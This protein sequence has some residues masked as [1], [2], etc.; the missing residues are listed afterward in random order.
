MKDYYILVIN[1]GSTSMKLALYKNEEKIFQDGTTYT[2]EQLSKFVKMKEQLDLRREFV[3]EFLEKMPIEKRELSAVA[4]RCGTIV[5]LK[6]GAYAVNDLLAD[7]LLNR[8]MAQHP[9]NLA[10]VLGMEVAREL[11][12]P[13]YTYDGISSSELQAIAYPTGFE[14]IIRESRVH[15]LNM[16]AQMRKAAAAMGKKPE[17]ANI[18]VAHIGGGITLGVFEKGRMIDVVNDT[19]GPF[20]PERCGRIPLNQLTHYCISHKIPVEKVPL[21]IRGNSGT[22]RILGTNSALEME[23]RID[24][25]DRKAALMYEAMAYQIS[26]SIGELAT[27]LKG[28]VDRIVLTGAI[29][30]SRRFTVMICDRVG[31]IAPIAIQAG[32]NELESLCLGCLRVLRGE[33]EAHTFTKEEDDWEFTCSLEQVLNWYEPSELLTAKND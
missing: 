2:A 26:K 13:A 32:E 24:A 17:E 27:V 10:P 3:Q 1:P 18:I 19:E 28:K 5:P 25:G 6:T 30:Y 4:C 31:F 8:P 23:A 29:A 20:T 9:A 7:R 16:R 11:G 33:E 21:L 22:S 14:G 12:I 15:V